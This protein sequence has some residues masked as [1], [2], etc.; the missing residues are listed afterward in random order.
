[1]VYYVLILLCCSWG[2]YKEKR[3]V[4]CRI[5]LFLPATF[6]LL[7]SYFQRVAISLLDETL[8]KTYKST[9]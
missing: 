3:G 5:A 1:M 8:L 2:Y 4:Y 9:Y 7:C 6:V